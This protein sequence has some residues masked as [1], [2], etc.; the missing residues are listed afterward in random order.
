MAQTTPTARGIS[1]A[2]RRLGICE[3]TV[4]KLADSGELPSTRTDTGVRLFLDADL[5]EWLAKR[6]AARQGHAA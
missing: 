1:G 4:R 2:A 5:D 6:A 3:S